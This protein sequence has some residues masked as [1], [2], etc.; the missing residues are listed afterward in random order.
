ME[1]M[2][3]PAHVVETTP[4]THDMSAL[5]ASFGTPSAEAQLDMVNIDAH[6]AQEQEDIQLAVGFN[7]V[8]LGMFLR[9]EQGSEFAKNLEKAMMIDMIVNNA[10]AYNIVTPY[11]VEMTHRRE[12]ERKKKEA[13]LA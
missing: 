11:D 4:G 7:P 3:M 5:E 1:T 10:V 12:E 8:L 13:V 2:P 6:A 9:A